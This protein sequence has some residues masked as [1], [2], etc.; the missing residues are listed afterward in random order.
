[1]QSLTLLSPDTMLSRRSGRTDRPARVNRTCSLKKNPRRG[2]SP[3]GTD[4]GA[5]D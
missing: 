5:A 4:D 1:V 2:M 3:A